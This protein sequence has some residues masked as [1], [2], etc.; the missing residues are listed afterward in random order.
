MPGEKS[1]ATTDAPDFAR[2][3][4]DV[5]VPAATSR[6]RCPGCGA[7]ARVVATRQSGALPTESTLLVR[8]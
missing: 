1:A 7:T 3:A 8:S 4:L 6:M 2:L 5:P